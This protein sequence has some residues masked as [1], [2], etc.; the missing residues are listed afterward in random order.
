MELSVWTPTGLV[1]SQSVNKIV[2]VGLH[3]SFC[4]LGKH[5]DA[6]AALRPGI[7]VYQ[8][9]SGEGYLAVHEGS[10]IK[11]ES[12]VTVVTL[13]AYRGEN[14]DQLAGQVNSMLHVADESERRTRS[15]L[16][17]LESRIA[18]GLAG[19]EANRVQR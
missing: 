18:R 15:A 2:A 10:L 7:L 9:D 19:L 1:L 12:E 14:L 13:Q 8:D 4:I 17:G 11:R 16:A 5:V 6:V 3:G